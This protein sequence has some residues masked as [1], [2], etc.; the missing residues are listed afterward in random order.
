MGEKQADEN[1]MDTL[2]KVE[3]QAKNDEEIKKGDGGRQ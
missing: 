1:K 2:K 3:I